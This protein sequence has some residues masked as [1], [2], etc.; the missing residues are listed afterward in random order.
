METNTSSS[1]EITRQNVA[2]KLNGMAG[3]VICPGFARYRGKNRCRRMHPH[4]LF[5]DFVKTCIF[6]PSNQI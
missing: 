4:P 6:A 3:I 1:R 2:E 5:M